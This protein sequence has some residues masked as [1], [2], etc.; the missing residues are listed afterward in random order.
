MTPLPITLLNFNVKLNSQNKAEITWAAASEINNDYFIIER[1][2]YGKAWQKVLTVDGSGNS[3]TPIN[4]FSIDESPYPS[5]TYY[6]L[7]QTDFDGAYSNSD[8]RYAGELSSSQIRI[9]IFPN[10]CFNEITILPNEGEIIDLE[11]FDQLGRSLHGLSDIKHSDLRLVDVYVSKLAA[12][13]Y[14]VRMSNSFARIL[15]N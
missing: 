2:I 4:Y 1:S 14:Y 12:G 11:I 15:K 5:G 8:V 10:P 7:K 9:T 6:R 3:A 13:A